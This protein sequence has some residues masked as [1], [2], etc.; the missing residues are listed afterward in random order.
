[1]KTLNYSIAIIFI[2]LI[3]ISSFSFAQN[4]DSIFLKGTIVDKSGEPI[5]GVTILQEGTSNGTITDIN[6]YFELEIP[7]GA[8]IIISYTGMKTL[9]I[10]DVNFSNVKVNISTGLITFCCINHSPSHCAET[11]EEMKRLT[12]T[13]NCSF[14]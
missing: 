13:R 5:P 2:I 7:E 8:K 6:G 3:F 1:M 10:E 4:N 12:K 9:E 11:I 14:K